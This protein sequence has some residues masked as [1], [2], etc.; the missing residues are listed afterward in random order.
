[1]NAW[2]RLIILTFAMVVGVGFGILSFSQGTPPVGCTLLDI[3]CNDA[4]GNN[5][6]TGQYC[7]RSECPYGIDSQRE[8]DGTGCA[9]GCCNS[10]TGNYC[11]NITKVLVYCKTSTG[12]KCPNEVTYLSSCNSQGLQHWTCAQ[13]SCD[14]EWM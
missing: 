12:T 10:T 7:V 3:P 1:M 5:R 6:C 14:C 8:Y 13:T 11:C 2:L 4:S 9:Y